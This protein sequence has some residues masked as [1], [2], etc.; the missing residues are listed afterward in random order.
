MNPSP[1]HNME[2]FKAGN[3]HARNISEQSLGYFY[4]QTI[5]LST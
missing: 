5:S 2:V 3:T 1:E 4:M